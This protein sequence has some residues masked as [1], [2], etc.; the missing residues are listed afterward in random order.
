MFWA[1]GKYTNMLLPAVPD[2][3]LSQKTPMCEQAVYLQY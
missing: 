1:Y 2:C 3:T